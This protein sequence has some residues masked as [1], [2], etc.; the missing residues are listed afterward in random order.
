MSSVGGLPLV[1]LVFKSGR[2]SWTSIASLYTFVW[3]V[4]RRCLSSSVLHAIPG[5]A[6]LAMWLGGMDLRDFEEG[7][8]LSA[9]IGD[10]I[11]LD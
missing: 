5:R 1:A 7:G 3:A 2:G 4:K 11:M 8:S 9:P 6:A 10:E